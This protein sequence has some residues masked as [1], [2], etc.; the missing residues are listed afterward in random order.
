MTQ[1]KPE[2]FDLQALEFDPKTFI[3]AKPRSQ[4]PIKFSEIEDS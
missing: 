2:L 4:R 1:E 3:T